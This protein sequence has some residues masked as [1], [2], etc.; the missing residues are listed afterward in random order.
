[1]TQHMSLNKRSVSF[2]ISFISYCVIIKDII[3]LIRTT[4]F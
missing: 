3:T 4:V 2:T 1:V